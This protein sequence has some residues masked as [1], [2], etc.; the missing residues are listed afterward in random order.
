MCN[1]RYST[2]ISAP[3]E[4]AIFDTTFPE[5][6]NILYRAFYTAGIGLAYI[7]FAQ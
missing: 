6:K 2:V 1:A 3:P 4:I 7:I 5:K